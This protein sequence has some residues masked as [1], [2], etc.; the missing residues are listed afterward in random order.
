[1]ITKDTVEEKILQLSEKKR[2]LVSN[3]LSSDGPMRGLTK[4]DVEDLFS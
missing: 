3:V 2:E 4:S 1:L